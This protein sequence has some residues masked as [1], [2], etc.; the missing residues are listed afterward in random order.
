MSVRGAPR[1]TRGL[2]AT[3]VVAAC[4]VAVAATGATAAEPTKSYIVL[5]GASP[6]IAYEG[7]V[8]GIPATKPDKGKK[9]DPN[10]D[11]VRK[12]RGHLQAQHNETLDAVGGNPNQKL[13]DYSVALNGY[14]ALLTEA[15][16]VA[17]EN[18]KGVADVQEDVM[19]QPTTDSSPAFLGLTGAGGAYARGIDGSGVVVG[20]IDTGIWP[21]HPSFAGAGFPSPPT[22]G[23]LP[24]EFGN[25]AGNPADAPFTCNNKLIGA[26][27]MLDTYR[28]L[29][30]ADPDEYESARDDNGHGTHTA[31]TTAGNANVAA[32]VVGTDRGRISGIAPRAHVIAY[33]GLGNLGG[34]T[35]DLADAI[36]QAV[37]DGVDVINYSIGGGCA[38]GN[39]PVQAD[40]LAFLFAAQAGVF[41]AVSAGN[42]GP[43]PGTIGSPSFAP[44]VTTVGA[45]TQRRF[46]QATVRLGNNAT[47]TGASITQGVG[48]RRIVDAANHANAL[49]SPAVAFNP[50]LPAG[51]I[52][53]CQRGVVA[54]VAK[55]RAVKNAGG[56]GM[57][58]FENNDVGVLATDTHHVPS[59]HVDNTP[60]LAIKAY[61][62]AQGAAATASI[63]AEQVSNWPF[64]P[65]MTEFSSRGPNNH[66][67]DFLKP[68][69]TAPGTQ[70]LAGTSPTP[71]PVTVPPAPGVGEVTGQLFM[72][73]QGTSMSSPHVAGL[74]ALLKEA[75]PDW[76]ASA[77]KSALM[78]T[79][80]QSVLN[81]DRVNQATPFAQGAG[82]P[83]V[84][85]PN[86]KGSAFQPGIVYEAGTNAY[87]AAM[88]DTF[89]ALFTNP[90]ATCAAL[91]GLGFS[92][93]AYNL[94]LPSIGVGALPGQVTVKRTVTSVAKDNGNRTYT[95][96]VVEPAGYD[97]SVSPSSFTLKSGETRSYNV[98]I[99]NVSA[100]LGE[101]RFGSLTW[102]EDEY[103]AYT[104]IAV[105][106]SAF[107]A[108]AEVV[109]TGGPLSYQVNFGYSGAFAANA[110]GLV[111][112]MTSLH[113][114][115]DD[116]TDAACSLTTP[117]AALVPVTIAADTPV[118]R[119]A[120]TDA[121]TDGAN[122]DLDL[123]VFRGSQ[124]VGT[125]GGST[126]EEQ[127]TI[128]SPVAGNYTVVIAPFATDGPSATTTLFRWTPTTAVGNMVVSGPSS[129]TS[130]TT[131]T[132]NL[133]FP[134]PPGLPPATKYLGAVSYTGVPGGSPPTIVTV[135][136]P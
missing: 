11:N 88:C 83:N 64:A 114:V 55:S 9:I 33:K 135:N 127:V 86:D 43:G 69:V 67:G 22:T 70:I 93:K 57:V 91:Q 125:S 101:F 26:Y 117:N 45:N 31:S 32:T 3:L 107:S 82:Q 15:Q 34:F 113:T 39:C 128:V 53:L 23:P 54:R 74:F 38:V 126:S 110:H 29:I 16:A 132:I 111:P 90:T 36:D 81:N 17:L 52:V 120:L 106:A 79:A 100:P 116:P 136:K 75:N 42:S 121:T 35:S 37:T 112:P 98:T 24:C 97:I 10:A 19:K 104:P 99:T 6:A 122:D 133:T 84:G 123:C 21:E 30:G 49:C 47:Y 20:I 94:N 48:S 129:A 105:R 87:L 76:S 73:I 61:I 13:N 60:G 56:G 109:G 115:S 85:R 131:G 77:A 27:E 62:A 41:V 44:W 92:T 28:A 14:S 65:S 95:A 72:A 58:M 40:E 102:N 18:V 103:K 63:T 134:D 130:G 4:A 66:S 80:N 51:A 96:S 12:Y 50:A 118:A 46:F 2:F 68:D 7:G 25:I 108:P 78:T 124:N 89:P 8:A 1:S 119:F 71:D 59:V 5:M